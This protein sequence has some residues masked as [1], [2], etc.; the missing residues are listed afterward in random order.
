MKIRNRRYSLLVLIGS[1]VA[2]FVW[3]AQQ[4]VSVA[5][6]QQAPPP[7][8]EDLLFV[9]FFTDTEN[10]QVT[11]LSGTVIGEGT[12]LGG[13]LCPGSN[14]GQKTSLEFSLNFAIPTQ[15]DYKFKELLA[16][17]PEAERAVVAGAGS[18]KSDHM[19]EKFSFTA[20][21]QNNRDGTVSVTYGA[22]RPDASVAL[23]SP[24]SFVI[25]RR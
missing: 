23:S 6:A 22:S 11:D 3:T 9:A 15:I 20:V 24:G 16:L 13:V 1:L 8:D 18:I 2:V 5:Q 21:L 25:S 14:C 4:R 19:N 12:H 7:A 10:I 17:D